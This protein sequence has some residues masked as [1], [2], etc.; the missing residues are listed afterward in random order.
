MFGSDNELLD[1][2]GFKEEFQVTNYQSVSSREGKSESG[3]ANLP[4]DV[5]LMSPMLGNNI[6]ACTQKCS[7]KQTNMAFL[8]IKYCSRFKW[9]NLCTVLT[10]IFGIWI[11][12]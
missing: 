11:K 2:K 7:P 4:Q 8:L 10:I 9:S 3:S 6:C 12:A 1:F 5:L